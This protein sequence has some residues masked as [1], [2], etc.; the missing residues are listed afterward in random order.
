MTE[1]RTVVA[2]DAG[3]LAVLTAFVQEFWRTQGLPQQA[4]LPFE[5][6]LEEAFINVV[7]HGTADATTAVVAV[8]LRRAGADLT[9]VVADDGPAF[10]PLT[11]PPP[12]LSASVEAR[13]VGGLGVYLIRQMMDAV[14][15]RRVDGRNELT[16]VKRFT[17]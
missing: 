8:V 15:Y 1:A 9:L 14:S 16:M 3:Q 6:A 10:D 7:T 2:A 12:D 4:A 11:L 17:G 5:L 13:P